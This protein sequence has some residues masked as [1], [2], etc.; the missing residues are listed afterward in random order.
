MKS[1][2]FRDLG[3][4]ETKDGQTVQNGK[5]FRTGNVSHIADPVAEKIAGTGVRLYIDF[6]SKDEI[7]MFGKPDPLIQRG[8]EWI[9]LEIDSLDPDFMKLS[10]PTPE[11]W[12]RLYHKLFEKNIRSWT[13]FLETV[14]DADAP[15]MYGCLFGKDRTGIATALLLDSLGVDETTI[16][17]NYA[18]TTQHISELYKQFASLWKN[19]EL[20]ENEIIHYFMTA[21]PKAI[22]GFMLYI[23]EVALADEAHEFTKSLSTDLQLR[24]RTRLL[25]SR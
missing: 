5:V 8:V 12:T 10:R 18:A 14:A 7:K 4:I 20:E 17:A 16:A 11:D 6:R 13:N 3:G 22:D 9:N 24:L 23:R 15:L 21:H 2:N 19:H 25:Q 1:I